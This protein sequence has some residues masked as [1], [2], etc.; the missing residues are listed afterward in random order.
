MSFADI[1]SRRS[2]KQSFIA[3]PVSKQP[4][5]DLEL[6]PENQLTARTDP[7]MHS[8]LPKTVDIRQTSEF[9][10]GIWANSSIEPG[11]YPN[12][13]VHYIILIDDR[14]DA[15]QDSTLCICS[16]YALFGPPLLSMLRTTGSA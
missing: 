9:G 12:E 6:L 3:P 14:R 10:R 4:E 2:A 5:P 13:H 15:G 8:A 1:K 7:D 11:V 16:I